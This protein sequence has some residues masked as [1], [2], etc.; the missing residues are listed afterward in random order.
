MSQTQRA[1]DKIK[2][3]ILDLESQLKQI[4][5]MKKEYGLDYDM[6]LKGKISG[7]ELALLLIEFEKDKREV[8]K[9]ES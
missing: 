3:E 2:A 8:F 1:I 9:N 5:R 4:N 6:I 7:L